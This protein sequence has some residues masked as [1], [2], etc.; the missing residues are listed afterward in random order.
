MSLVNGMRRGRCGGRTSGAAAV[1]LLVLPMA[2]AAQSCT[3]QAKLNGL[4]R[5]S[6]ADA[7]LALAGEVKSDSVAR[8]KADAI[9]EYGS[10][11]AAASALIDGTS[12]KLSGDTLQ[13]TQLYLLDA[14]N[15][16][17]DDQ[18]DAEF[19]CALSGTTAEADFS[20]SGLP[21][22]M[23]GFAMVEATGARPWL[24]SM[25]LRQDLG[26]WKLAGLYPHARTAAGHD[27]LWYWTE[28]RSAAKANHLWAA[29]LLYG[30]ADALLRPA[31]FMT[32]TNLDKL[33]SE[34][35]SATP[36]ELADGISGESPLVLK[37]ASGA[38]MKVTGVT[39][40]GSEDGARLNLVVHYL[41]DAS[42][43]GATQQMSAN[44]AVVTALVDA[45][46]EL[47]QFFQGAIAV[48]EV[49]GAQPFVTEQKM[50]EIH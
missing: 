45:H 18:T 40:E 7:A 24:V 20:I 46:P 48:S 19:S 17:S 49:K 1:L 34:Q 31:N 32:T 47:R 11:F 29:W 33:R 44:A 6:L 4:V 10:N 14:R 23:Y 27:G 35:R 42:V 22:G 15:R 12:A 8:L 30:E 25:L 36:A 13:V 39:S 16:K 38:T 9:E 50:S 26:H 28:A 43:A 37:S 41:G 5:S 2:A 21:P 3:T